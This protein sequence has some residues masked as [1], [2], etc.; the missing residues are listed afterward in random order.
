MF[1]LVLVPMTTADK[2]RLICPQLNTW[3]LKSDPLCLAKEGS[4]TFK[5]GLNQGC[6][7]DPPARDRDPCLRDR[8]VQILSRDETR[9]RH[10]QMYYLH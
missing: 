8:D 10:S 7:R 1:T 9:P 5:E 2:N 3:Q 6:S 4:S